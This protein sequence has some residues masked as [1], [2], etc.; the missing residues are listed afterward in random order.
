MARTIPIK[1]ISPGPG[2]SGYYP[3]DTLRR[4]AESGVFQRGT[5]M[6][7]VS[8]SDHAMRTEDPNRLAAVL[9]T[10]A[11][12]VE[13]GVDGPG[14]YATA[15]VFSDFEERVVE[16]AKHM[17]LSIVGEGQRE[18]GSLPD[19]REGLIVTEITKGFSVD[20]VAKPGR[21]GKVLFESAN[22]GKDKT[23]LHET[24]LL[25]ES[26]QDSGKDDT[27]DKLAEAQAALAE[28][29]ASIV[30]LKGENAAL[31][32]ANASMRQKLVVAEAKEIV[33]GVWRDEDYKGIPQGMRD[34]FESSALGSLPMKDGKLDKAGLLESVRASADTYVKTLPAPN[35]A[36][37][38]NGEHI[39]G[40]DFFESE[41]KRI[42]EKHG[43]TEA[44]ARVIM[45]G[46]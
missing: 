35:S 38:D 40:N 14:L 23:L 46:A 21:D 7:W 45:G 17:G 15:S 34:L 37:A 43:I 2:S 12:Y 20:F 4:A 22:D 41:A 26:A 16:K 19:G 39:G 42:A 44:Q 9:E 30:R 10:N 11:E 13:N 28:A 3:A 27:M 5:Q 33:S 6:F 29:K 25:L 8:P 31:Q 32:E 1:L 24:V 18:V 36:V